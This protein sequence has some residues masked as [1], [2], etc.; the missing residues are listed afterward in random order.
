[1]NIGV[2]HNKADIYIKNLI[3]YQVFFYLFIVNLANHYCAI[4]KSILLLPQKQICMLRETTNY[5][6]KSTIQIQ[7][8]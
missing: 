6:N 3:L 8:K 5:M 1:M 4:C 2:T 7:S